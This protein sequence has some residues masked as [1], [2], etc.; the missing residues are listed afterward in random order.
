MSQNDLSPTQFCEEKSRR[1][2]EVSTV[3]VRKKQGQFFT[4]L[5]VANFMANLAP[6][7]TKTLRVLDP[8]AGTGM[9][10][11]AVCENGARQKA[12]DKIHIDAYEN[13]ANLLEL[14]HDSMEYAR[15][16]LSI[17]GIKLTYNIL[18]EDFI[19]A[20]AKTLW[21]KKPLFYDLAIG[22]PPYFKISK[23][24]PRA[25][26]NLELVYGQPN[27]YAL[28]MGVTA[29]LL[30][31]KG[32]MVFITPRSYTAGHYF[33]AF[34]RRFFEVMRPERVHLFES[35]KDA[36]RADDVLQEN[37][38]LMASKAS[39]AQ[40]VG[41]SASQGV[42]DIFKAKIRKIPIS[43]AL[44]RNK[45][46]LI[47]RL[48]ANDLEDRILDMVDEWPG[49]LRK[50]GMEISTGPVVLFRAKELIPVNTGKNKN[51][52]PLLWMQHVQPMKIQWPLQG[53]NNNKEKHQFIKNNAE[54]RKRKLLVNNNNLVLLRRFSA[55]EEVRRLVA[56]PLLMGQLS[57]ELIGI[58]NHLNY[59]YRLE[60]SLSEIEALGL[61]ALLNSSLLDRYFRTSNGNTQVS[62][63]ELR[64]MPLPP[65]EVLLR[66]GNKIKRF[67]GV[68]TLEQLDVIV[69][70]TLEVG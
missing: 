62:A 12:L 52:V 41:I 43:R 11:C 20:N 49:S 36:F 19:L 37:I 8:G 48:P 45:K 50:H 54:S 39:A 1:F 32:V 4:P 31:N 63:T 67:S 28:F 56:A 51:L 55:K 65:L 13:D 9:L 57:S 14:L 2:L 33:K 18:A 61:S 26:S 53:N 29:E 42:N 22:N 7:R 47:F 64:A 16:W 38:I 15:L 5:E 58:E 21:R 60:G 23:S 35:R 44:F 25:L 6:I 10:S 69:E 30:R 68:P 3:S 59:I 66:L 17:R 24:D 27:I 46:D 40:S 70:Q 34:R